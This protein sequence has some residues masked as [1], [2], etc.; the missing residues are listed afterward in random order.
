MTAPAI[1]FTATPAQEAFINAAVEGAAVGRYQ[2]LGYGG[3]I[4]GGKT[5]GG[6]AV[7]LVLLRLYPGSRAAIV[8]KDLPTLRRNTIPSIARL[9]PAADQFLGDLNQSTWTY[10]CANGSELLLFAE[11][12]DQD[13]DL[14]RWKG[15]EVNWFLLEEGNELSERS[16][17]KAI[18]RAGALV[19]PGTRRQ[20][21]PLVLVTF[22]PAPGW[23]RATFYDPWRNGALPRHTF[24]QPA[25]VA[26]NP[27]I[28]DSYKASLRAL[29]ASEYR[30]F[31]EG[32]WD[33]VAGQFFDELHTDQ[34]V[35]PRS[36]LPPVLPSF[37]EQW[38][39]YDWGFR[40]N[41]V[42]VFLAEDGDGTRY[43]LDTVWAHRLSDRE[44]A[45]R[46]RE[47]AKAI[48]AERA[49]AR[50]YAGGDVF[51][52]RQAH[53]GALPE[54]VEDT[55]L[56][57]GIACER[58]YLPRVAGWRA[59]RQDLTRKQ[60]DGTLGTPRLR[61]VDTPGNRLLLAQLTTLTPDANRP[62]DVAKVDADAEGRGG[63]DGADA[64]RYGVASRT[65]VDLP[66]AGVPRYTQV[67][68]R[69]VPVPHRDG[70]T[71]L[72]TPQPAPG[73]IDYGALGEAA[74]TP[75][76]A[77]VGGPA[78]ARQSTSDQFGE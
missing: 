3:G 62:E 24:Y 31:V 4:R 36:A 22:N 30:R 66:A 60:P 42:C 46:I 6:L 40:H 45:E 37:W 38:A 11:S 9:R 53:G 43:A 59:L 72:E 41:A 5:W 52:T 73:A 64:L 17:H 2:V 13:R 1:T 65:F 69:P 74:W 23:V 51:N 55:F 32:D 18:E 44:Q 12:I 39:G 75:D 70:A 61:F 67:T 29:P 56:A 78:W 77:A 27:H 76:G 63:D 49:L 20:P 47:T 28:P 71:F 25:L 7:L 8:R 16:Y 48:G 58:A 50:V 54:S 26:D 33:A 10:P 57:D 15:L 19:L 68:G 35:I 21:H 34:H 14:D